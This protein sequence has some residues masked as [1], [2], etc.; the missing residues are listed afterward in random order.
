MKIITYGCSITVPV[1]WSASASRIY[2]KRD[3]GAGDLLCVVTG[4]ASGRSMSPTGKCGNRM[5]RSSP[6]FTVRR[7]ASAPR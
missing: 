3:P 1:G 6:A 7:V 4:I 5:D 2:R